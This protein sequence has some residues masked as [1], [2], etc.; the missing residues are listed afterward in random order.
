VRAFKTNYFMRYAIAQHIT[1]A[2]LWDA[3][4]R[5]VD[6]EADCNLGYGLIRQRLPRPS[7]SRPLGFCS[8]LACRTDDRALFI[9]GF[10]RD[11]SDELTHR[12]L[13]AYRDIA[14]VFLELNNEAID[15]LIAKGK[16]SEVH[17]D[18]EIS[19]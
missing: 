7:R 12:D 9:Y 17:H 18:Q 4:T 2:E 14:A 6:P 15:L 13:V 16:F 8:I 10:P 1:D 5:S 11:R 3:F 19:Q